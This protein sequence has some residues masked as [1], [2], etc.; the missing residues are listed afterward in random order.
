MALCV[1]KSL[2]SVELE[3]SDSKVER[4]WVRIRG[5]ANKIDILVG[6]CYKPS[7]QDEEGDELFYKQLVDVSKPPALS[8]V[9]DFNL[10][11]DGNST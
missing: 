2:D 10:T 8:F 9:G 6:V 1:R 4:L 11:N 5:S 3:V 7:N